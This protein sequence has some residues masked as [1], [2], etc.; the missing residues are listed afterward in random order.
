M[1][2]VE[3]QRL[4]GCT[5]PPGKCGHCLAAMDVRPGRTLLARTAD[6]EDIVG[7]VSHDSRMFVASTCRVYEFVEAKGAAARLVPIKFQSPKDQP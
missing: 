3:Y 7:I 5:A 1:E 6:G 2:L 4:V